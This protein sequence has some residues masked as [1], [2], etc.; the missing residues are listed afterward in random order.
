M[1]PGHS[2]R[3]AEA[4]ALS[5]ST[6]RKSYRSYYETSSSSSLSLALPIQ[7]RYQGT[8]KL[9]FDTD[10]KEDKIGEEDTDEDKGH[11]LDDKGYGLDDEVHSIESD[12]LG[13]EGEEEVVPEVEEDQV[14][15]T[16]E[17]GQ[18][19]GSIPEPER[20][21]RVLALRHP[22]LTTWID[23][24]DVATPTTTILVDE[25]QFIEIGAQL[26]LFSG[27]L[28]DHTQ[29]LDVIPPTLCASID[30]DVRELY[31]RSS[32]V[33][34]EIFSQRARSLEESKETP[35]EE[36]DSLEGQYIKLGNRT[37]LWM[38]MVEKSELNFEG[39]IPLRGL[40]S[41]NR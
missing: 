24:E 14:Y 37:S 4:M 12:R 31:T 1:S 21:E 7:K 35:L 2:A 10:S 5:D 18:G 32:M 11:G 30:R 26:E 29:R 13:L 8:S 6:L 9:I 15:S 28:Q 27:I 40:D 33:R 20:P 39:E 3:V 23:L 17:V 25:D 19:S 22:T 41:D 34:D 38:I 16:Y 36:T